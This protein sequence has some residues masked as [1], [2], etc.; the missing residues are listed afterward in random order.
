MDKNK[1]VQVFLIIVLVITIIAL[2]FWIG[3]MLLDSNIKECA[4][5]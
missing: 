2:S 3:G 5:C 4:L 1:K